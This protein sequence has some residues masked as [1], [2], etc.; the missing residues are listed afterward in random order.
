MN[1]EQKEGRFEN[2]K[3]RFRQATAGLSGDKAKEAQGAGERA[4]GSIK[5]ALGDLKQ[6]FTKKME[7]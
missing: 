3:G 1:R 4:E 5:K 6:R 7:H 2:L